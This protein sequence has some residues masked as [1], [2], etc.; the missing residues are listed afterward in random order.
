MDDIDAA[1]ERLRREH[2]LGS[3]PGGRLPGGVTNRIV[4]LE[5]PIFLEL[6]GVTDP[7]QPDGAW[8][9]QRL[10]GQD[11]VIW[12]CLVVS[13]IHQAAA[14]RGLPVHTGEMQ[15]VDG[16]PRFFRTAAMPHFPLPFFIS[17]DMADEERMQLREQRYREAAHECEPGGYTLLEVGDTPD[18][19]NAWIGEHDLPVRHAPDKPS[20][21]HAAGI[22]TDRGEVVLREGLAKRRG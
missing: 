18:L 10:A 15:M 19:L 20:G 11:Q 5:P 16:P 21:I 1:A 13:D 12:W 14:Q 6:L 7:S 22:A 17:F 3:V 9:S 4:P 2:G 8:L